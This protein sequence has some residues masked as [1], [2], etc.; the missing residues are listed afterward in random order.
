MLVRNIWDLTHTVTELKKLKYMNG[1]GKA[2]NQ[3]DQKKMK[4]RGETNKSNVFTR[5][6]GKME[7]NFD[8]TFENR[9]RILFLGVNGYV[10]TYV[11]A[12]CCMSYVT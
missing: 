4:D 5:D 7:S 3:L 11:R 2:R 8:K 9:R 10:H 1:K 6:P 12:D